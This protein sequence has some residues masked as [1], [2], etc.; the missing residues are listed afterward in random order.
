LE[1]PALKVEAGGFSEMLVNIQQTARLHIFEVII[2][3]IH[4]IWQICSERKQKFKK[5][6]IKRR[7]KEI[8]QE[9]KKGRC[10]KGKGSLYLIKQALWA[11]EQIWTQ[12]LREKNPRSFQEWNHDSP[13]VQPLA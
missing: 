13:V 5:G 11:P 9:R 7:R 12:W 1:E 3:Y 2:T 6:R 8:R 10:S 4:K